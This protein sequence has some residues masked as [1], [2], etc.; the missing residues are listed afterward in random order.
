MAFAPVNIPTRAARM[1]ISA[2]ITAPP[3]PAII[4][5]DVLTPSPN[6][7]TKSLM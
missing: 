2:E 4:P 5:K 6:P 7:N 3:T 1:T